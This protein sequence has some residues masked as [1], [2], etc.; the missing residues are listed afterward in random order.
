[1]AITSP[2]TRFNCRD[3]HASN[4]ID[5]LY[6]KNKKIPFVKGI[7]TII[8]ENGSGKT[9]LLELINGK[10]SASHIKK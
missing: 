9:T 10:V 8:G 2:E 1:M 3:A 5:N 4:V 7:N 6:L